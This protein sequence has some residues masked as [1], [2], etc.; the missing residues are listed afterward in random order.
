MKRIKL[1]IVCIVIFALSY[2]YL[3]YFRDHFYR[4]YADEGYIIFGAKRI[5]DGQILY[6]DFFQFYPPGDFY[7]LA[8]MFKLFGYSFTVARETTVI[9][10]SIITALYFYLGYKAIKSWHVILLPFFIIRIS[11]LNFMQYSHYWS[12]MLFLFVALVFFLS[13]L[14]QNKKIYLYLA[15]FFIG[16]TGLFLQTTGLYAALLIL[17]VLVLER[18]REQRFAKELLLF[19]M[20]ISIPL[21]IVC[22]YII[23]QGAFID[24]VKE[25]YFMSKIYGKSGTLNP[26]TVYLKIIGYQSVIFLLY[27]ATAIICGVV[28]I[29]FRERISGPVK[30]ILIGDMILFLN[31]IAQIDYLH[32][33]INSCMWFIIVI[34]FIKWLIEKT[35][36][37]SDILYKI[38]SLAFGIITI[39][40]VVW[41]VAVMKSDIIEI[42]EYA[43]RININ[44]T[45]VWTFN[46]Q[47]AYVL[48]QF[49]PKVEH[50]LHGEKDVFVYPYGPLI[51][52]LL[53]LKNPIRYDF[54]PVYANSSALMK[55]FAIP[56]IKSLNVYNVNYVIYCGWGKDYINNFLSTQ[57]LSPYDMNS[58]LDEYIFDNYI[59]L[60]KV[61]DMMLLKKRMEHQF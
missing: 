5:L 56:I 2:F 20:S 4:L 44:G 55:T 52:V 54:A 61:N 21:V 18:K 36:A 48:S 29:H 43:Y 25:Q 47:Q 7:L 34:L 59:V 46:A 8:L 14:E 50:I 49:L 51:Y 27:T 26:I 15:G 58:K 19:I 40:F 24:F 9:I 37:L 38:L 1:L 33:L 12:S 28:L 35:G 32:L 31:T 17:V 60:L 23:Y 6:K 53:N 11:F 42:Y 39:L 16:I 30:I 22:G 57:H 3:S 45:H 41:R 13:Y 10:Q